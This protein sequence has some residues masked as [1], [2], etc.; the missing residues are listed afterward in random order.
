MTDTV[1]SD[2]QCV[3]LLVRDDKLRIDRPEH[4]D[5]FTLTQLKPISTRKAKIHINAA[6][7]NATEQQSTYAARLAQTV[8]NLCTSDMHKVRMHG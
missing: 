3:S 8:L 7:I 4:Q 2:P 5:F 1:D 6:E